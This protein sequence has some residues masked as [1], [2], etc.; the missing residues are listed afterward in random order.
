MRLDK[1][2]TGS[3]F[4]GL[5]SFRPI[6]AWHNIVLTYIYSIIET[7]IASGAITGE[8]DDKRVRER[9]ATSRLR[10]IRIEPRARLLHCGAIS[11]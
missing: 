1:N 4:T 2:V 6:P 10:S 3:G 9:A 8:L 5:V 11:S 7:I